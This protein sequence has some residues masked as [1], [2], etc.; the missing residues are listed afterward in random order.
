MHRPVDL[1]DTTSSVYAMRCEECQPF[2]LLHVQR[3]RTWRGWHA[4]TYAC[5]RRCSPMT[6]YPG[7]LCFSSRRTACLPCV[8]QAGAR[9]TARVCR[10][11]CSRRTAKGVPRCLAPVPLVD[12]FLPCVVKKRTTKIVYR[13][14]SGV[15]HGKGALPC[16]MLPCALCRAPRQ[17]THGKEFAV[18]SWR[19]AKPRFPV[20][21]HVMSWARTHSL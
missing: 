5:L 19:T 4:E 2:F 7:T 12:F 15:A 3:R 10:A 16:K 18:R 6:R 9:Q 14:L 11:F 1:I 21:M 20:V 13:A 17:K 8:F